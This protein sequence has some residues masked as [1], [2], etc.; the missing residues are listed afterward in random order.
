MLIYDAANLPEGALF[1]ARWQ[2]LA[3]KNGLPGIHFV[4]HLPWH[5]SAYD[6][7]PFGFR[8]TCTVSGPSR[9]A[10]YDLLQARDRAR[11]AEAG[12]G[13]WLGCY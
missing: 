3:C 8:S 12:F 1:L 5:T 9:V 10:E 7:W 2:H 6:P 13:Q 11:K 4:A